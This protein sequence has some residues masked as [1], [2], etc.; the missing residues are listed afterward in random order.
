ML[1]MLHGKLQ[2]RPDIIFGCERLSVT[3][4]SLAGLGNWQLGIFKTVIFTYLYACMQSG[5][6]QPSVVECPLSFRE[7]GVSFI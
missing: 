4:N 3:L 2:P 6:R 1:Q 5:A 7:L